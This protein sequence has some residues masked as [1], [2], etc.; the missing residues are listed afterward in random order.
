MMLKNGGLKRNPCKLD[1]GDGKVEELKHELASKDSK[2]QE[3]EN[4]LTLFI[5]RRDV[6][7]QNAEKLGKLYEMGFIDSSGQVIHPEAYNQN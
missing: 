2:I 5:E 4:E 6:D 7:N 3:L 1:Q